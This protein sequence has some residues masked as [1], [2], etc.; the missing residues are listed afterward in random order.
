M[1][2]VL[3]FGAKNPVLCTISQSLAYYEVCIKLCITYLF[4]WG[5]F[6][7]ILLICKTLHNTLFHL[8]GTIVRKAQ[9][10]DRYGCVIAV[11]LNNIILYISAF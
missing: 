1:L 11:L 7:P 9:C 3:P 5:L 2:E 10:A 6:A 4:G 8:A